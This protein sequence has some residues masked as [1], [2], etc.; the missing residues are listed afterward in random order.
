MVVRGHVVNGWRTGRMVGATILLA[1]LVCADAA[2]QPSAGPLRLFVAPFD[3]EARTTRNYWVGEGAAILL[4]DELS[5]LGADTV[6]REGRIVALDDLHLPDTAT[7]ARATQVRVAEAVGAT[8]LAVGRVALVEGTLTVRARLLRLRTGSYGPEIVEE[9][10]PADLFAIGRRL[11]VRL[12]ADARGRTVSPDTPGGPARGLAGDPDL[13]AFELYVKGLLDERP[14]ARVRLLEA[15]LKR[16]PRFDRARLALWESQARAGQHAAAL[17]SAQAVPPASPHGRPARFFAAL[18]LMELKRFEEAFTALTELAAEQPSASVFN[19][20]GVLQQRRG[21]SLQSGRPVYYFT[22][23]VE[24]DPHDPDLY[25][26]LGYAYWLDK[27]AQASIYWL[28]EAVRRQP[29]DADAHFVLAAALTAAGVGVEAAR[30]REL[31]GRLSA[32][33]EDWERRGNAADSVPKGLE[34]LRGVLTPPSAVSF[35]AALTS[36]AQR[37]AR[38]LSAFYLDRGRRLVEQQRDAEAVTELRKALYLSPY[39]A[40]AHL[41]LGTAYLRSRRYDEAVTALRMSLWSREDARARL[42][43]AEALLADGNAAAALVEARRA[44]ALDPASEAAKAL[45]AK[46]TP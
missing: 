32:R 24:A 23:A 35:D 36:A 2:A 4:A 43:L 21:T 40:E 3:V 20:L 8:D 33:Y 5:A 15:A 17:A 30:E 34:R 37:E 22:K 42:A 16:A 19:N 11:A 12:L 28:R 14:D 39:E 31:A 45:V 18:S 29:L 44:L 9:G 13:E 25:F 10:A 46:L 26:N 6:G 27:D 41:L 1:A 7:L 38:E